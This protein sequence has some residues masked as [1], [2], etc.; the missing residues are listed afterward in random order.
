[1]DEE[2]KKKNPFEKSKVKCYNCQNLRHFADECELP[3]K[4]KSKG[5]DKVNVAQ[6]EDEDEESSLLMVIVTNM[7][8]CYF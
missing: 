4:D 7:L 1:M 8:M 5:K 3:K 6:E 2:K